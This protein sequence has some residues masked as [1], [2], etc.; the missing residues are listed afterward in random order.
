MPPMPPGLVAA[1]MMA[2]YVGVDLIHSNFYS[3]MAFV[4]RNPTSY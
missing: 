2:C 4:I 3:N 1:K